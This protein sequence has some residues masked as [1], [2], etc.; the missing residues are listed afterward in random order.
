LSARIN[1]VLV[2]TLSSDVNGAEKESGVQEKEEGGII[3]AG[4]DIVWHRLTCA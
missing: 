2:S 4:C 1:I 3:A